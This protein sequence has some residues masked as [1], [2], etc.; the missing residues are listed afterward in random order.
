MI[1]I[2]DKKTKQ[3]RQLAFYDVNFSGQQIAQNVEHQSSKRCL[4][5]K[6]KDSRKYV[7]TG[8]DH[9]FVLNVMYCVGIAYNKLKSLT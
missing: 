2:P 7:N 3:N 5:K 6:R 4:V 1:S 8:S 9:F